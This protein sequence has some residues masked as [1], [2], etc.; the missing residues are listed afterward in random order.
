MTD[1]QL[2]KYMVEAFEH[3]KKP[4]NK[5]V[6]DGKVS[7]S[8]KAIAASFGPDVYE[9]GL[10][11]TLVTYSS[12]VNSNPEYQTMLD[13]IWALYKTVMEYK[14]TDTAPDSAM[15]YAI[16]NAGNY[17]VSKMFKK[18]LLRASVAIKLTL[19]SY[20]DAGKKTQDD[21]KKKQD[22]TAKAEG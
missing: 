10:V 21:D 19:R 7:G 17:S 3:I 14:V 6:V 22:A 2:E 11:S 1:K 12:K 4:D 5:V 18:E 8:L 13:M 9:T 15:D 20:P 16:K